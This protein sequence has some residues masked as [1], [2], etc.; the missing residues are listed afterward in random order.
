MLIEISY[1]PRKK[2]IAKGKKA[3]FSL[4]DWAKRGKKICFL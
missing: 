2:A 4:M 1:S 3:N